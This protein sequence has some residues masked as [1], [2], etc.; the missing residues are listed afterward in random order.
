MQTP[1]F[2]HVVCLA[3][4]KWS[5]GVTEAGL[6]FSYIYWQVHLTLVINFF[7]F[8]R[9]LDQKSKQYIFNIGFTL[10]SCWML[11]RGSH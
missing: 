10:N 5:D 11:W 8:P 3:S 1:L 9:F 6:E 7:F 2:K 4:K